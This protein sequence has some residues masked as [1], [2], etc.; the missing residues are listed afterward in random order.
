MSSST[1][2][3]KNPRGWFAAGSEVQRAMMIL[4][5]GAFKLFVY[6]CLNA[7]RDSATLEVSQTDLARNLKKTQGTIRSHLREMESSGVCRSQFSRHPF[8]RGVIQIA[9]SFWPYEKPGQPAVAE[10][11]SDAFVSGIR[12]LLQPRACIRTSFS[13]ADEILARRWFDQ[14]VPLER[15]DRAI[16]MGCVRKYVAWRNNQAHATIASLAYFEPVLDEVERQKINPEYWGYLR[17][18]MQRMEALWREAHQNPVE[19]ENENQA[20]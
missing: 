11:G 13:V 14:G 19:S 9:E 6:L 3:L 15:I 16:L 20:P 12:Q 4:S 5:D 7:R 17:F 8:A 1:L 18:R 2:T 10:H